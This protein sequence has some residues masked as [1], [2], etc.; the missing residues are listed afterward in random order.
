MMPFTKRSLLL[1]LV[2]STM[3]GFYLSQSAAQLDCG[4]ADSLQ[5]PVDTASFTLSQDYGVASPRHQGRYHTGEDWYGGRGTSFGQPVQAA[6][7]GRVTYSYPLGWGRD[8]G[9]VIIEHRMPDESLIYTQYGHM[10]ETDA[11]KFP[12]RETCVEAGTVIGAI[13]DARPGPHLHFEVRVANPDTPGPGYVREQP[14]TLGWR[15]PG[16]FMTNWTAWLDDAHAW[17]VTTGDLD[18]SA[19]GGPYSDPL[20]LDDNSLLLLDRL[21]LRRITPDGRILWRRLLDQP[22]VSITGFQGAPLLTYADGTMETINYEGS[23]TSSWQVAASFSGAPLALGDAL[24]FP[25]PDERLTAISGN[26]RDI[27]WQMD[28]VPTFR[29]GIV[30]GDGASVALLTNDQQ[31]ITLSAQG[32]LLDRAQ[33]RGMGSLTLSNTGQVLAYTRGGLWRLDGDGIWSAAMD[34]APRANSSPAALMTGAGDT[35]LFDGQQVHAFGGNGQLL[36]RTELTGISGEAALAYYDAGLLLMSSGGDIA[37]INERGG[38]CKRLRLYSHPSARLWHEL[39]PDGILRIA[40][41]DQVIGLD[42]AR[43]TATCTIF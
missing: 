18:R 36:W 27:A 10:M 3:I 16:K 5:Y 42:W 9:V 28:G 19:E 40:I 14:E 34:E 43:L 33:L 6:A 29:R 15:D 38:I 13:T 31:I 7:R 30:S 26:R 24:L 1:S 8:G 11:I 37:V 23:P 17:H 20:R 21:V 22:A 35:V 41:A 2:I 4:T 25:S 39:G 12:P 32:M